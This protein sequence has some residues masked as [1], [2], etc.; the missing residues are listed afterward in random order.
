MTNSNHPLRRREAVPPKSDETQS[1]AHRH[2]KGRKTAGAVS[3]TVARQIDENLKRLYAQ[4]V[5]Q[6]LPPDLQ[7]LVVRLR[8][9]DGPRDPIADSDDEGC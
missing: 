2:A 5:E 1:T 4:L 6:E 9:S 7:A 8:D 3:P